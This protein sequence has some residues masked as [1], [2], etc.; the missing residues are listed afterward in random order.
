[1]KHQAV[2]GEEYSGIPEYQLCLYRMFG[3]IRGYGYKMAISK[4]RDVIRDCSKLVLNAKKLSS[5]N[6]E[7]GEL[8]KRQYGNKLKGSLEAC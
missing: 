8:V 2:Y 1:M 4:Y 7:M 6:R 3:V 5:V